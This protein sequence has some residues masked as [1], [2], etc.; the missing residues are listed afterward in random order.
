MPNRYF[1][2][3][4]SD[5]Q[6]VVLNY[7]YYAIWKN[8][9][10]SLTK[11]ISK[12]ASSSSNIDLYTGTTGIAY[13]Y[14]RLAVL[15]SYDAGASSTYINKAVEMLKLKEYKYNKKKSCQFI[16]GDAGVN[17]V[18]AAIYHHIGDEKTS[19]IHLENFKKGLAICKPIDFY[20]PGGDELFVGRAGYLYGVLW[21]EKVFGKKIIADQDIIELCLTIVESGRKYSRQN[22]SRFPLMYSYYNTEYLGK[23]F[24]SDK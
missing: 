5:S 14:Y 19:E 24:F 16:C 3:I 9:A 2:N 1:H 22:K 7:S 8:K 21:L 18:H 12:N 13:M 11:C 6:E 23:F 10:Y 15:N 20:M 4:F 17:A